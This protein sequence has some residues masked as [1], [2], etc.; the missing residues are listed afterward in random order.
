MLPPIRSGAALVLGAALYLLPIEFACAQ[1]TEHFVSVD[2]APFGPGDRALEVEARLLPGDTT[3]NVELWVIYGEDRAAVASGAVGAPIS[4]GRARL[5]TVDSSA[6]V[7]ATFVFPHSDHPRPNPADA[8]PVNIRSGRTTHYKVVKLRGTTR[9]ES[10]IQTFT[11]PDKLTIVNLG[12]SLASGEGAPYVGG[13][14]RW[15]NDLCHRSGNSG[16]ARAVRTIKGENPG[17]AIAFKNV[18][19]S[20]AELGEGVMQSQRKSRWIL[21]PDVLQVPVQ[22]QLQAVTAWL[23]ENRYGEMNIAMLSGGINDIRFGSYVENYL[24]KPFVFEAGSDAADYLEST[25]ESDI[26]SLYRS[27]YDVLERD[28]VYDRILVSEYPDPLR[29]RNG[30][31]CDE[32]PLNPRAEYRAINDSFL[33]PLNTTIRSTI[34]GFQKWKFVSGAMAASRGHGLCNRSEPY[35]NNGLVE[36]F[37]TQGDP[38]GIVHPTRT[39][40][41]RIYKPIYESELRRAVRDVRRRA[42]REEMRSEAL[43]RALQ[44]QAQQRSRVAVLARSPQRL[45]AVP[46]VRA[47]L[48]APTTLQNMPSLDPAVLERARRVAASVPPPTP[49]EPDNRLPEDRE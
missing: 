18:A 17:I 27:L 41:A 48:R 45:D 9:V 39:G 2:R 25:I 22:P 20:G 37:A 31:F 42:A 43:E 12:D 6:V 33:Y 3:A 30:A 16:Q 14:P 11:M 19:C 40:H 38:F 8:R 24:I 46:T 32:P 4:H 47:R 23:A 36:S 21:Q 44:A 13:G 5:G 29:G 35:F 49:P 1:V 34:D 15:D 7:R 28:F 26:P 10:E